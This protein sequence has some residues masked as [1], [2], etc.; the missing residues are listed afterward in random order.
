MLKKRI[1]KSKDITKRTGEGCV[2]MGMLL[3]IYT[4]EARSFSEG[5]VREKEERVAC[6]DG[7]EDVESELVGRQSFQV[8]LSHVIMFPRCEIFCNQQVT[9]V[10]MDVAFRS[11]VPLFS[12]LSPHLPRQLS[13]LNLSPGINHSSYLLC[14]SFQSSVACLRTYST[15][16]L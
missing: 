4:V 13:S 9:I 3:P 7:R 6:T 15:R 12:S 5:R 14:V 11:W 8:E 16:C 10:R 1:K 2:I